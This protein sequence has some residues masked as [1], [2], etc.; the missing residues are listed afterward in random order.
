[1][2]GERDKPAMTMNPEKGALNLDGCVGL[3]VSAFA[4]LLFGGGMLG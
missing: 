3:Y 2:R 4:L 1:M